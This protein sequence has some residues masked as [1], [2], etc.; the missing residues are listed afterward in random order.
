M[1][2]LKKYRK[3]RHLTMKELA[4]QVGVQEATI[5]RYETGVRQMSVDMARKIAVV[6]KVKCW[7]KLYD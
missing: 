5:C 2:N 3:L 1:S 6:L 4:D 7:W